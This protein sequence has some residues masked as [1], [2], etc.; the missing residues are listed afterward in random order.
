MFL[1]AAIFNW[2]AAAVV[3]LKIADPSL[4]PIAS[5]FNCF[6]GQV[7]AL[8]AALFGYGYYLVSCDPSR[9]EGIV[10]LGVIGKLMTFGLFLAHALARTIPFA[11]VVPTI[12]DALFA[13]LFLEFLLRG[14]RTLS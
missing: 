13:L 6:G 12:A 14:R 9:N 7:F 1:F 3:I 4:V 2:I 10:Q 11:V 5:P 8:F